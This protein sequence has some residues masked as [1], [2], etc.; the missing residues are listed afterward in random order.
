MQKE[1]KGSKKSKKYNRSNKVTL[2]AFIVLFA[3]FASVMP[4]AKRLGRKMSPGEGNLSI[5]SAF[6]YSYQGLRSLRYLTMRRFTSSALNGP[7]D[8]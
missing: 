5:N 1:A 6:N 4:S 3:F 8:L 7:C 2:V